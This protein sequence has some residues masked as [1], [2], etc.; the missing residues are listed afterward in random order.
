M[1]IAVVMIEKEGLS[2][3]LIA[4]QVADALE[5]R[6]RQVR[7]VL[8]PFKNSQ[9]FPQAELHQARVLNFCEQH[10]PGAMQGIRYTRPK[11]LVSVFLSH[12]AEY[13]LP[14]Q[15]AYAGVL[16]KG[17]FH[18]VPVRH[19]SVSPAAHA[20]MLESW[21]ETLSPS[22]L[23]QL[24]PL[25]TTIPLGVEPD[26]TP[27]DNDPDRL[28]VPANRFSKWGKDLARNGEVTR[29]YLDWAKAKGFAPLVQMYHAPGFG[30]EKKSY[31]KEFAHWQFAEQPP[32]RATYQANARAHGMFLCTSTG[33]SFGLYYLELLASGCV[34]VFLD[35]PWVRALLPGYPFIAKAGELLSLLAWVRLN[36]AEARARL[37][38]ETIPF[39]HLTYSM[40]R[41]VRQLETLVDDLAPGV[42]P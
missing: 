9:T 40:P 27:G 26:F 42:T 24:Q 1:T 22:F 35:Q 19:V 33:E 25:L 14:F 12:W 2:S 7:R 4:E 6:G 17:K 18:G 10:T 39:I 21:R 31:A 37:D 32:D 5:A 38:A 29:A 11:A 20:G 23:R 30:P 34:G 13:E 16:A 15:L 28:I 41:F 8:A 3:R 36:H